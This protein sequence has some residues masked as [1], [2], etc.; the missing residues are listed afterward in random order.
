[1]GGS[2]EEKF[3]HPTQKPVLL[4]RKPILNHTQPGELVYEPFSGSGT[5]LVAAETVGRVCL[6]MELDPQ[7]ADVT[8]QRWQQLTGQTATLEATSRSFVETAQERGKALEN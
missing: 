1:M 5:T 7:Y 3:D 2:D 6:A 4:M 8:V